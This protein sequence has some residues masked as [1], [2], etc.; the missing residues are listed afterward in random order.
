ML[1]LLSLLFL[2]QHRLNFELNKN[3][4]S[5]TCL[6]SP[7]ELENSKSEEGMQK[8]RGFAFEV[9][10]HGTIHHRGPYTWGSHQR[11]TEREREGA[12]IT[13]KR[14]RERGREQ[15]KH[16]RH[17]GRVYSIIGMHALVFIMSKCTAFVHVPM[18][19]NVQMSMIAQF[20]KEAS[21]S[22]EATVLS[23]PPATLSVCDVWA[24]DEGV[25]IWN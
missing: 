17:A 7:H 8:N 13:H 23:S 19:E 3:T 11:E 16:Q 18:C 22:S 2:K 12:I 9:L 15:T 10:T 24:S 20:C 14:E 5:C 25:R 21:Q 6:P 1:M 4:I